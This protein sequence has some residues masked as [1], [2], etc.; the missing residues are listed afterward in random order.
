MLLLDG[1]EGSLAL[2]VVLVSAI[3]GAQKLGLHQ[4]GDAKLEIL[5]KA[6]IRSDWS[7]LESQP[8]VRTEI[9]VRI[10]WA[11]VILDWSRG[12]NLGYCSIHPSHFNTRTP[13]HINDDDLWPPTQHGGVL[14]HP[15]GRPR[16]EFTM[17]SYTVHA[18]EIALFARP[19]I[20][21]RRSS[22]QSRRQ[23]IE[24]SDSLARDHLNKRYEAFI[25]KLPSHFRSGSNAGHNVTGP[26]AAIPVHRWMLHQQLWS[27]FLRLHLGSILSQDG[28]VLCQFLVQNIIS[29]QTQIQALCAICGSLGTNKTQLFNAAMVL[30]IDLLFASGRKEGDRASAQLNRLVIR[31]RVREAI[32]LLQVRIDQTDFLPP[33]YPGSRSM[34]ASVRRSITALESLLTLEQEEVSDGETNRASTLKDQPVGQGASSTLRGS[35]QSLKDKILSILDGMPRSENDTVASVEPANLDLSS[36]KW[37]P[38]PSTSD[39]Q[40]IN[41]LPLL[42][43]DFGHNIWHYLDFAPSS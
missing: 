13:L 17:L 12:L 27:L 10:W 26:L 30:L 1:Q 21:Y 3:S 15:T 32:E 36:L 9:G 35:R 43:D 24:T 16:S 6:F 23:E 28:R 33:D 14:D 41:L 31:D 20:D 5:T 42:F 22:N 18:L 11:L 40:D 7:S 2:D 38:L 29:S 8:H 25:V 37:A 19:S 4:L 39:L 34:R